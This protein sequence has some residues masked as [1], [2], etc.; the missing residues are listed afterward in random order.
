M[1]ET[2]RP[3]NVHKAYHAHVYFDESTLRHAED[4]CERAASRFSL[5]MGRV[6]QKLVGPHPRWSCQIVFS[7]KHFDGLIKCLNEERNGLTVL[8]H[9]VTGDDMKDHTDYAYWL[10]DSVALDLSVFDAK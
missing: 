8:V 9:G 6:H 10:G 3:I 4:L 5:K 1:I 2:K 7:S